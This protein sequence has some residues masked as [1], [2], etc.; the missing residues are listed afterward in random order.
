M[1]YPS[2]RFDRPTSKRSRVRNHRCDIG[3]RCIFGSSTVIADGF[4]RFRDH[5]QHLLDQGY[6]FRPVTIG[7]GAV[8]TSKCTITASVG[9]RALVPKAIGP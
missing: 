4:H 8:A 9:E 6:D 7:N 2:D 3:E 1:T 5:S